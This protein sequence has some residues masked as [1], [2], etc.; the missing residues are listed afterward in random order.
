M[1]YIALLLEYPRTLVIPLYRL[2]RPN[3]SL[4]LTITRFR[5]VP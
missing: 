4:H 3:N 2:N 1:L 5:E